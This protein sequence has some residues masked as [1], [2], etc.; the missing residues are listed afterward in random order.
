MQLGQHLAKL[1]EP[2]KWP[3]YFRD[4]AQPMIFSVHFCSSIFGILSILL[5]LSQKGL[6]AAARG[7][8]LKEA[9]QTKSKPNRTQCCVK[10]G[11]IF[12]FL[13]SWSSW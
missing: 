2:A 4:I 3:G 12:L 9:I 5:I 1:I 8:A 7:Q 13:P 6:S 11:Q 10:A